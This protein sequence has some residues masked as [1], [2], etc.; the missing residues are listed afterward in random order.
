LSVAISVGPNVA[1][2]YLGGRALPSRHLFARDG[3]RA[4]NVFHDAD[5]GTPEIAIGYTIECR[6]QLQRVAI[7]K[8]VEQ[9]GRLKAGLA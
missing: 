3:F 5:Q 9:A 6:D 1:F 2:N 4:C 8:D 7:F